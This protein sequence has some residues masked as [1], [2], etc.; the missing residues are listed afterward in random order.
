MNDIIRKH[1]ILELQDY[2][3]NRQLLVRLAHELKGGGMV[4]SRQYM[5]I[6]HRMMAIKNGI[7]AAGYEG[8]MIYTLRYLKKQSWVAISLKLHMGEATVKR[9]HVLLLQSVAESLG[10]V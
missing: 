5:A 1:V 8:K 10:W 6:L 3:S 9:K 2:Q 4:R 7:V